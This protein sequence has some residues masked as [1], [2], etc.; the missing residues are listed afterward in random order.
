[1]SDGLFDG[2]TDKQVLARAQHALRQVENYQVGSVQRAVQWAA[3]EQAKAELDLRLYSYM[4]RKLCTRDG[5]SNADPR[6][7]ADR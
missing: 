4:M 7:V 1:V 2:L 3:Y 6:S 5:G